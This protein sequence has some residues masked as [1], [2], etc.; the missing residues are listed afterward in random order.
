MQGADSNVS[1]VTMKR[2]FCIGSCKN[3]K[4]NIFQINDVLTNKYIYKNIQHFIHLLLLLNGRLNLCGSP[5][6]N[7]KSFS[8]LLFV[9][10]NIY[11]ICWRS[12]IDHR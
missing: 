9:P 8:F 2:H 4:N 12:H 7:H 11:N 3:F 1:L 10:F 5:C 6:I